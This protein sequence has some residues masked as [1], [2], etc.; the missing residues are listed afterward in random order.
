MGMILGKVTTTGNQ[1]IADA[2]IV[3]ISGPTHPELA[4]SSDERGTFRLSNLSQGD[5]VIQAGADGYV[6]ARG[7][8]CVYVAGVTRGRIVL[9]EDAPEID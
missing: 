9:Q 5:Y 7:R 2:V 1:P 6:S 8:V 3:V 4:A